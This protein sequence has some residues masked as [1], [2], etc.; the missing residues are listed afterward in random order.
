MTKRTLKQRIREGEIIRSIAV[1]ME[2]EAGQFADLIGQHQCDYVSVDAQ[3]G[4]FNE[5]LLVSF[6]ACT[7]SVKFNA[8][9]TLDDVSAGR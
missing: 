2:I 5:A 3:H 1:P 8:I 9:A 4:P 6:C 7:G